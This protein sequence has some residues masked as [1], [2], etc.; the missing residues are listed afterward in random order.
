[1]NNRWQRWCVGLVIVLGA[2]VNEPDPE[3][4]HNSTDV[5]EVKSANSW[6]THMYV[7]PLLH[8]VATLHEAR[9]A[10][11]LAE[12]AKPDDPAAA[13]SPL[14][15]AITSFDGKKL[16]CHEAMVR[17]LLNHGA[18]PNRP[19]PTIRVKPLQEALGMGDVSCATVLYKAGASLQNSDQ[20]LTVM[21]A[22]TQGAIRTNSFTIIDLVLSWGVDANLAGSSGWTAL[23]EAAAS[24][25]GT[26]ALVRYL[27]DRGVNPCSTSRGMTPQRLAILGRRPQGLIDAL[28]TDPLC[29]GGSP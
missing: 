5:A 12:G 6:R 8:A 3:G 13:R 2:C 9:V 16:F 7:T 15:Q 10:Q 17:L 28:S 1:M 22:A 19:D 23:H 24:N 25:R 4:H 18:D 14:V 26:E 29:R 11:L 21:M 20:Q 27:L